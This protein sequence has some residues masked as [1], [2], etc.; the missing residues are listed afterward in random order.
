MLSIKKIIEVVADGIMISGFVG[1]VLAAGLSIRDSYRYEKE[2]KKA[3]REYVEWRYGIK[4]N[5]K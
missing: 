2:I 3:L 5:I 4:R 1:F